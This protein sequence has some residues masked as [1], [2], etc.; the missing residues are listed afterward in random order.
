MMKSMKSPLTW[1]NAYKKKLILPE[2]LQE[3]RTEQSEGTIVTL[4][5]SFDL[6]HVGHLK[7][8]YE[9]SLQASILLVALNSDSSIKRYKSKNR[10]ILPL[11]DRLQMIAALEFVDYVTYFDE[12]DPCNFLKIIDP[13]IHVNSTEYGENCVEASVVKKLHLVS[14]VPGYSTTDLIQRIKTCDL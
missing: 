5:G 2:K 6:L 11:E 3:W 10:P 8:I 7:M 14:L 9:A 4:N 12:V 1:D 13:D